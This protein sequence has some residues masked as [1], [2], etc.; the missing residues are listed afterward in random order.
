M[1]QTLAMLLAADPAQVRDIPVGR[2]EIPRLSAKFGQPFVVTFKAA[3]ADQMEEISKKSIVKGKASTIEEIRW[4]VYEQMVDPD[5]HSKELREKFGTVRPLDI[6]DAAKGG[7]F[8][9]G[10]LWSIWLEIQKL[11]G[12]NLTGEEDAPEG[13][14]IDEVKNS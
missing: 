11:S 12:M 6:T 13:L 5:L 4:T 10:E 7:L 2:I 8:L 1:G 9:G 14:D 3:T